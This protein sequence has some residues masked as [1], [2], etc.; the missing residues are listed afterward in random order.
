MDEYQGK[1][2]IVALLAE[3]NGLKLVKQV[4]RVNS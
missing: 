3:E 1:M 2:A 4:L